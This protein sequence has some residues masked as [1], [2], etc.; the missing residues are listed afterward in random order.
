[1]TSNVRYIYIYISSWIH[2]TKLT[3]TSS[4]RNRPAISLSR[5]QKGWLGEF[6]LSLCFFFFLDEQC[7]DARTRLAFES[8]EESSFDGGERKGKEMEGEW[9]QRAMRNEWM[10]RNR[11]KE[12]IYL[13]QFQWHWLL[14]RGYCVV[15]SIMSQ[16]TSSLSMVGRKRC[17]TRRGWKKNGRQNSNIRYGRFLKTVMPHRGLQN[18]WTRTNHFLY[19]AA[20]FVN[21]ERRYN[22]YILSNCNGRGLLHIHLLFIYH[23]QR[24]NASSFFHT[25]SQEKWKFMLDAT[26]IN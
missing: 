18:F 6:Y 1:M 15:P 2:N 13:P 19:S 17:A 5:R 8:E 24:V 16:T 12:L 20:L 14:T 3:C 11:N 23:M 25:F 9:N 22:P 10:N 4:S 21:L 26:R 7:R